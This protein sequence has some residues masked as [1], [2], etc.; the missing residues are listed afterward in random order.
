MALAHTQAC[1]HT[2]VHVFRFFPPA[3]DRVVAFLAVTS[4]VTSLDT[5]RVTNY[6]LSDSR[7]HTTCPKGDSSPS[8]SFNTFVF[9]L[10]HLYV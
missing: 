3:R 6:Q 9:K 4:F 10:P 7:S 2:D 1:S 8:L 5:T